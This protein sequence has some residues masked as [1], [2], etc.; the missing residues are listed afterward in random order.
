MPEGASDLPLPPPGPTNTAGGLTVAAKG[1]QPDPAETGAPDQGAAAGTD[2]AQIRANWQRGIPPSGLARPGTPSPAPQTQQPQQPQPWRSPFVFPNAR[3]FSQIGDAWWPITQ[4]AHY[5]GNTISPMMPSPM[6]A[7]GLTRQAGNFLSQW[8]SPG[9]GQPAGMAGMFAGRLGMILDAASKGQFSKN[10]M[11]ARLGNMRLMQ[12]QMLMNMEQAR[13]THAAQL[14]EARQIIGQFDA[15]GLTPQEAHDQLTRWAIDNQHEKALGILNNKGVDAFKKYLL[16]EDRWMRAL[17]ASEETT[18]KASSSGGANPYAS[19]SGDGAGES[20]PDPLAR[21]PDKAPAVGGA[22]TQ[23]GT[24]ESIQEE[25]QGLGA[26]VKA[27]NRLNDMGLDAARDIAFQGKDLPKKDNDARTDTAAKQLMSAATQ[28][29]DNPDLPT[30]NKLQA[31]RAI[32]PRLAQEVQDVGAY[33]IDLNRMGKKKADALRPLVHALYPDLDEGKFTAAHRFSDTQSRENAIM[34]RANGVAQGITTVF[35]ALDELPEDTAPSADVIRRWKDGQITGDPRWDRLHQ[36]LASVLSN[37]NGVQ[38]L[39]GS[40]KVSFI[41]SLM[42]HLPATASRRTIR[43]ALKAD[44][45]D[46]WTNIASYQHAWETTVGRRTLNPALEQETWRSFSTILRMNEYTGQMPEGDD[47]P[48][49]L[50]S[51]SR[52]PKQASSNLKAD[53]RWTPVPLKVYKNWVDFVETNQHSTD[54]AVQAQIAKIMR[55]IRV[56]GASLKMPLYAPPEDAPLR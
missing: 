15:G 12:E 42:D 5:P 25:A 39:T 48:L 49:A 33:K 9:V 29:A 35:A 50:R 3:D 34:V 21:Q 4:Q 41:K 2:L 44:A 7:L 27:D 51:V 55:A 24:P 16:E 38:N 36:A 46:I 53:Q 30:I 31:F 19:D 18:K 11:A 23:R 43:A 32:D 1:P 37:I 52:D 40:T 22:L 54:P 56:S 45:S 10:Y 14:I 8:A 13:Q 47:V 26:K 17:W 20:R 6:E 28:I